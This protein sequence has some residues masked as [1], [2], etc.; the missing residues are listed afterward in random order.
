MNSSDVI[1]PPFNEDSSESS[2]A[3]TDVYVTADG[4]MYPLKQSFLTKHKIAIM[5]S[6]LVLVTTSTG[7]LAY[8]GVIF[9]P[10][11][12]KDATV[13]SPNPAINNDNPS[14]TISTT[15]IAFI[16]PSLKTDEAN[17]KPT[18]TTVFTNSNP[19]PTLAPTPQ[20]RIPN[21]PQVSIYHPYIGEQFNLTGDRYFTINDQ[22]SGNS[23]GGIKRKYR[24]NDGNWSDYS[25]ANELSRIFPSEGNNILQVRYKNRDGDES[26]IYTIS[27]SAHF[28]Q[29]LDITINGEIYEDKNCNN[30]KDYNEGNTTVP[31]TVN[32]IQL[33]EYSLMKTVSSDTNGRYTTTFQMLESETKT[34]T[35]SIVAPD[36]YKIVHTSEQQVLFSKDSQS[37]TFISNITS[38]PDLNQC[39]L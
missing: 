8:K 2:N 9:S 26:Q 10:K 19:K 24:L 4:T 3:Q 36:G 1:I 14:A 37:F 28:I 18:K 23:S 32:L 22:F 27:F 21:P 20:P 34:I 30:I 31:A 16:Q 39:Q 29:V 11:I 17:P 25:E 38:I 15:P 13:Y 7:T 5:G 12:T 6:L 33:P 35:A